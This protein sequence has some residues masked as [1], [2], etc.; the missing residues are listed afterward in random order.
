MKK[1]INQLL[2]RGLWVDDVRLSE[3]I[4]GAHRAFLMVAEWDIHIHIQM[5]IFHLFPST[6]QTLSL[7][8]ARCLIHHEASLQANLLVVLS[9]NWGPF[10]SYA[11]VLLFFSHQLLASKRNSTPQATNWTAS[12]MNRVELDWTRSDCNY[13]I[14][15]L[16]TLSV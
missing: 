2:R 16:L 6:S 7:S 3:H 1:F 5:I 9:S 8:L 13:L 4:A 12:S 10:I 15:Y 11:R 14:W